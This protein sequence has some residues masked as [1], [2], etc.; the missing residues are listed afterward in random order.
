MNKFS[1]FYINDNGFTK[2]LLEHFVLLEAK[3]EDV[4]NS[5]L[6]KKKTMMPTTK[7]LG[8]LE[9]SPEKFEKDSKF[10]PESDSIY[11][12]PETI[13]NVTT[14]FLMKQVVRN[15]KGTYNISG[16]KLVDARKPSVNLSRDEVVSRGKKNNL[17]FYSVVLKSVK[18]GT[19][20]EFIGSKSEIVKGFVTEQ[21]VKVQEKIQ[22][23][24]ATKLQATT[25]ASDVEFEEEIMNKQFIPSTEW[26]RDGYIE[27]VQG[28]GAV[29][30]FEPLVDQLV[31][32]L[33]GQDDIFD[34]VEYSEIY[35]HPKFRK[36]VQ[37]MVDAFK[38]PN[39]SE[40]IAYFK[41][42]NENFQIMDWIQIGSLMLGTSLFSKNV[43]KFSQTHIIHDNKSM[44]E[45]RKLTSSKDGE[46]KTSTV[47]M[48]ISNV[49]ADKLLSLLKTES[50]AVGEDGVIQVGGSKFFQISLKA[51]SNAQLGAVKKFIMANY[52]AMNKDDAATELVKESLNESIIKSLSDKLKLGAEK[53]K[54]LGSKIYKS[55]SSFVEKSIKWFK[56]IIKNIETQANKN[57]TKYAIELFSGLLTEAEQSY[58]DIVS[59]Y[60][61]LSQDEKIVVCNKAIKRINV[62]LKSIET[63]L[64]NISNCGAGIEYISSIIDVAPNTFNSLVGNYAIAKTLESMV[65][66]LNEPGKMM[67]GIADLLSEALI[68]SSK[69][70]IWIVY[71]AEEDLSVEAPKLIKEKGEFT[72]EKIDSFE[73][74]LNETTVLFYFTAR[75]NSASMNKKN[76]G[77]Y[78]LYFYTLSDIS[79]QD[80]MEFSLMEY[81]CDSGNDIVIKATREIT[82]DKFYEN[83]LKS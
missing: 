78:I 38:T 51:T 31:E 47:D 49:P 23:E 76:V 35:K 18:S 21:S 63:K 40:N 14:L 20:Y 81:R 9:D 17:G 36:I 69:F 79:G 57:K 75:E 11:P 33:T 80:S 43:S 4:F 65:S 50:T 48:V 42:N 5:D 34:D 37:P 73:K 41:N 45:F 54:A 27:A 56:G 59:N 10:S 32:I 52:K 12:S 16:G 44:T 62:V 66:E 15:S 55:V 77:S 1:S 67:K 64:G 26:N 46:S 2:N 22:K 25:K 70:P 19:V 71:S 60:E 6:N 3:E 53:I 72:R 13:S 68:G 61:A 30:N 28:V 8:L 7:I 82:M 24:R 74:N 83:I 39:A 58:K 29:D